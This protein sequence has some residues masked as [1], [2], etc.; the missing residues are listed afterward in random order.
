MVESGCVRCVL[1]W[2]GSAEVWV[3]FTR[4][5]RAAPDETTRAGPWLLANAEM[6]VRG[7]WVEKGRRV[8]RGGRCGPCERRRKEGAEAE[9]AAACR[10]VACGSRRVVVL[11]RGVDAAGCRPSRPFQI[12]RGGTD[13]VPV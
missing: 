5:S 1:T 12:G 2:S 7:G 9:T 6:Q 3:L 10:A 4:S 13:E 11:G 8:A